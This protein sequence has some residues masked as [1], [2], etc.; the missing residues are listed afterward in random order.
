MTMFLKI[1]TQTRW[2][3]GFALVCLLAAY[4]MQ[5]PHLLPVRAWAE[6]SLLLIALLSLAAAFRSWP[7]QRLAIAG[8]ALV[9]LAVIGFTV[10]G[11]SAEYRHR[12]A[13][14]HVSDLDPDLMSRLGEHLV[15]GYENPD[16]VRELAQRGL[17]GGVFIT[18]R[19]TAGKSFEQIR[20]ELAM[21]QDVRRQA[22]RPPLLI[23]TDQEGGPVSR[24][25]PPLPLQAT[26]ASVLADDLT[27]HEI[28][29][30]ARQ[31][32]TAQAR[33]LASLGINTN[34]SP[35]VDLKPV[36]ATR[37]LSLHTQIAER[38]IASDP[39][40]VAEVALAYSQALLAQGVMP[41]LKHFPGLGSVTSDTHHFSARLNNSLQDLNARDW[42]PF[43]L[44]LRQTP[45]LLMVGHVT[46]TA[47]DETRPASVSYR[48]L[49]GLIRQQWQF[50]GV[51][52]S[53][54]LSMAP[55]YNRGLCRA[56]VESLNAGMDLL[57]VS[58]D[59]KKYYTVLDCL[60]HAA[61][62]G[63]LQQLQ[64]S[65]ARLQALPWRKQNCPLPERPQMQD[66]QHKNI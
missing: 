13:I 41:T 52:I 11:A 44:V 6:P 19:N 38:A 45:A 20:A 60:R 56:S 53:D 8:S 24:L 4:N 61:Q 42:R 2:R 14:M 51:M 1:R 50:N 48:V 27:P 18:H 25:S 21:L 15:M 17:I 29:H 22:K 39:D 26:L 49:T 30:R 64:Q 10:S 36:R 37:V 34:F 54:D 32:G 46:V 5:D 31:Y 23:A 16:E 28:E 43:Q 33:A 66:L 12:R 65:H 47:L 3:L 63:E 35:V 55:I 57:L 59:W 9:W 40:R 58:Y 7:K 62:S